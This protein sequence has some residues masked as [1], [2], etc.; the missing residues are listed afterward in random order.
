MKILALNASHRGEKGVTA[1]LL[2][3]LQQGALEAGA[4]W[5]TATLARLKINRCLACAE[6]QGEDHPL[7]CVYHAKDDAHRVFD[8]MASADLLI[9][10]TPIYLM[11]MTGL[12]KTL[13]D[14]TYA[15]MDVSA[16][17]LSNG[18][19]HHHLNP[20]ISSKP[21]VPLIV[22]SN[23]ENASWQNAADYFRRYARFME[24]R[25]VGQLI[26]NASNLFERKTHPHLTQRFP[27]VLEVLAAYQQAGRELA[28]HGQ[29]NWRTQSRANQEV[30]PVPFFW[31][32]KHFRPIKQRIVTVLNTPSFFREED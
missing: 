18:L 1:F 7:T 19:I 20:A 25:Q 9:F 5:E 3:Q 31:L 29:L 15:T 11:T 14:R 13:L 16:V 28:T 21:F 30:I 24:T 6:C 12:M 26:R 22:C 17:R 23:L 27:K 2:H 8:Q 4:T 32:L 10:A